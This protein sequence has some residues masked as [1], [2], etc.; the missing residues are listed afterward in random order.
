MISKRSRSGQAGE[1]HL[2]VVRESF[3]EPGPAANA[4]RQKHL[5]T[6]SERGGGALDIGLILPVI[7]LRSAGA[8]KRD[9]QKSQELSSRSIMH[10]PPLLR[11][12][13]VEARQVAS[14]I[15]DHEN[16][17]V[18]PLVGKASVTEEAAGHGLL[19]VI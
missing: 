7:F 5:R 17:P 13:P 18:T 16:D 14:E 8:E 12:W 9:Q 11:D 10:L 6:R 15:L 2:L 1:A 4:A 3:E 19:V